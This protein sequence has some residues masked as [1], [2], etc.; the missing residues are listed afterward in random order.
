M[1]KARVGIRTMMI[2]VVLAAM[3][4]GALR[5]ILLMLDSFGDGF[6]YFAVSAFTVLFLPMLVIVE[7]VFALGYFWLRRKRALQTPKPATIATPEPHGSGEKVA[8]MSAVPISRPW[9][10]FVR[11]SVRG[12]IVVVLLVGGWLGWIVRCARIQREAVAAITK[13]GGLVDYNWEWENQVP[14]PGDGLGRP[15]GWWISS[16]STI[17]VTSRASRTCKG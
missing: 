3:L 11:F 13:S 1:L 14:V 5:F 4:M 12:M 9:R 16:G 17:S 8:A 15:G 10:R 7:S 6:L 2:V